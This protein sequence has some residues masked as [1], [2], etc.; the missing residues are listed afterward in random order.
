LS[1]FVVAAWKP[2]R[3]EQ[4]P[5][6]FDFWSGILSDI[7]EISDQ[8]RENQG[9]VQLLLR[10]IRSL[11]EKDQDAVLG[12]LL[13]GLAGND[14]LEAAVRQRDERRRIT[15]AALGGIEL[16]SGGLTMHER[17]SMHESDTKVVPIRFPPKLYDEL[18]GW[19]EQHH[20][21]MAAV[22]RGLVERF[23]QS[24]ELP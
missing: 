2:L 12:L 3:P 5:S 23:L 11:P 20:F 6:N 15:V 10:A 19:C 21:P 13:Q 8:N 22:V 17:L 24:Q 4:T 16:R 14:A 7:A 9:A 1:L 18:K